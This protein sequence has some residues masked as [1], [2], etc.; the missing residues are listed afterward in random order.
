MAVTVPAV[1]NISCFSQYLCHEAF[2]VYP[3]TDLANRRLV[4]HG[5]NGRCGPGCGFAGALGRVFK[6]GFGKW[7]YIHLGPDGRRHNRRCNGWVLLDRRPFGLAKCRV[8]GRVGGCAGHANA[9][10]PALNR[11]GHGHR[12]R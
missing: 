12:Q 5:A 7:P 9:A 2:D 6:S 11:I 3:S 1:D 8:P 4:H 10:A